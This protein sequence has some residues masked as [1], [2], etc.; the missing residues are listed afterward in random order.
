MGYLDC[1]ATCPAVDASVIA[2]DAAQPI[3]L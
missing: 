1:T 3:G 2:V